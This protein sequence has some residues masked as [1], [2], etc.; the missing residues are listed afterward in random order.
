MKKLKT[1]ARSIGITYLFHLMQRITD[2]SSVFT[3]EAKA[4]DLALDLSTL[5]TLAIN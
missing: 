2:D 3:A 1:L 4:D 5:V